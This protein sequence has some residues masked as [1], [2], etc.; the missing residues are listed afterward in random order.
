MQLKQSSKL[1]RYYRQVLT[2]TI[3]TV[4]LLTVIGKICLP[5]DKKNKDEQEFAYIG[6]RIQQGD[7]LYRDVWELKPPGIFVINALTFAVFS[8]SFVALAFVEGLAFLLAFLS[9]FY[10]SRQ[11]FDFYVSCMVVIFTAFFCNLQYYSQLGNYT[12]NYMILPEIL[13]VLFF[14]WALKKSKLFYL[15][16]AG[17]FGGLAF[18]TK[19]VGVA[20]LLADS[21][22]LF[23]LLLVR[24]ISGRKVL[25][26]LLLIWTGFILPLIPAAFY[27]ISKGLAGEA[28]YAIIL[29]GIK[30]SSTSHARISIVNHVLQI[31][32]NLQAVSFLIGL[33]L[34]GIVFQIIK[35]MKR[36]TRADRQLKQSV[37]LNGVFDYWWIFALL[38]L[39]AD[40]SGALAG[41]RHNHHYYL[42]VIPSLS[43][44]AGFS[45]QA[46][47][48]QMP[49]TNKIANNMLM[50]LFFCLAFVTTFDPAINHFS[51]VAWHIKARL[52][53]K[54]LWPWEK[55]ADYVRSKTDINDMVYVW[56]GY[57]IGINF[58]AERRSPTKYP[59]GAAVD[60]YKGASKVIG[61][62]IIRDVTQK[63]PKFIVDIPKTGKWDQWYTWPETAEFRNKMQ[64]LIRKYY[65]QEKVLGEVVIYARNSFNSS[66]SWQ[67]GMTNIPVKNAEK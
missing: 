46:L 48:Q 16:L 66:T 8:K 55:A 15:I 20:G 43:F 31:S 67:D 5:L 19:Q 39:G 26:N 35:Y 12:E 62:E 61:E 27:F 17:V 40:L 24:E 54:Q 41:G 11:F 49:S 23:L 25:R 50:P 51:S 34:A 33:V 38:W 42:Q 44:A 64:N 9:L 13:S 29:H 10:L 36:K 21:T 47:R 2:I 18:L 45:I 3:L 28:F 53:Q 60:A 56:G 1:E 52:F 57:G 59:G 22:F 7:L 32:Q 6:Y 37:L 65:H 58:R 63:R 4:I 14:V 30:Y